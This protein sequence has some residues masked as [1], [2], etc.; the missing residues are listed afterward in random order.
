[1]PRQPIRAL[2]FAVHSS[3]A[4]GPT[5]RPISPGCVA[6]WL[7]HLLY[8]N[9]RG[10]Q[11]RALPRSFRFASIAPPVLVLFF[12]L[13]IEV[14]GGC[15]RRH[16]RSDQGAGRRMLDAGRWVSTPREHETTKRKLRN[17]HSIQTNRQQPIFLANVQQGPYP[18]STPKQ[19]P[20][21][22]RNAQPPLPS[23]PPRQ[24]TGTKPREREEEKPSQHQQSLDT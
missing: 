13:F 2:S 14:D 22:Q 18:S 5:L 16:A 10:S 21:S 3:K 12:C 11:V 6:Q 19:S 8:K 9:R 23:I 15:W 20:Q 24:A 17:H 7:R 1:M 4:L